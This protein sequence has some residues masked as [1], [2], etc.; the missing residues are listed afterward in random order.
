[1]VFNEIN[2]KKLLEAFVHKKTKLERKK[3]LA[4]NKKKIIV[5]L[6]VPLLFEKKLDKEFDYICCAIAPKKIRESRTLARGGI[7]KK[8]IRLIIN[9]QT[10]NRVRKSRSNYIIKTVGTK[11]KTYLQVDNMIY[12]ILKKT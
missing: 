7:D 4:T 10:N 8:T 9:S 2:K 6:D 1:M 11:K 3:F 12:D 5:F